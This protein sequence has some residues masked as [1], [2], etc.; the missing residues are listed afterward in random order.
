MLL[1]ATTSMSVRWPWHVQGTTSC[2]PV[3]LRLLRITQGSSEGQHESTG[4][5]DVVVAVR[6]LPRTIIRHS[7]PV[8]HP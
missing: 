7:S 6:A 8:S 3:E 1:C 4:T 5:T 2:A